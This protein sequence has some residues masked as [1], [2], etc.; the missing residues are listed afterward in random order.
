MEKNL[1]KLGH[2]LTPT[3]PEWRCTDSRYR[4][5]L[6]GFGAC[7]QPTFQDDLREGGYE[8]NFYLALR[9]EL[10]DPY[11]Y[12]VKWLFGTSDQGLVQAAAVAY[13][14]ADGSL[15]MKDA[16]LGAGLCFPTTAR[17]NSFWKN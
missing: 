5:L 17:Q 7:G 12:R 1:M 9:R 3:H 11:L 8:G 10:L 13:D 15:L 14:L 2:P 4:A 16:Q 6:E